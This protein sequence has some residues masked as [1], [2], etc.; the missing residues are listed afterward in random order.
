MIDIVKY[1]NIIPFDI[2]HF[3]PR[4]IYGLITDI[5]SVITLETKTV[6]K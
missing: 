5:T 1:F 2:K 4:C 3:L 6:G